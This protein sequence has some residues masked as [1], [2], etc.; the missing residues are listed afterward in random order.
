MS[1]ILTS[2][3]VFVCVLGGA[4]LGMRLGRIVPES[5][6]DQDSKD[7]VRIS[8]G[9]V[10]TM[11][12]LVLGLL[13]ASAK[14]FYDT[15]NAEITQ[16]SANVIILDRVL[17]H[18]GPAAKP[19]REQ[20][21]DAVNRVLDSMWLNQ[22]SGLSQAEPQFVSNEP[23][24]NSLEN[25][26]PE[27]EEQR[28]LKTQALTITFGMAQLRWLM[29]TQRASTLPIP[30]IVA[31]IVWLTL[32]FISTGLFARP[33]LCVNASFFAAA[34]SVS[35]AIWLIWEMYTPYGGLIRISDSSLR[36][37]LSQLGQ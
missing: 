4:F 34:L 12:A 25:L 32:V 16:L 14:S 20:L 11:V 28:D 8:T 3:I 23:L 18:Y 22:Q 2:L 35:G 27:N 24:Y 21:R 36:A 26:K 15:Q 17:A 10:A 1:A 29:F 13:I 37:A 31:L 9:V 6:L 5:H 7:V 30:L 19:D 33:N